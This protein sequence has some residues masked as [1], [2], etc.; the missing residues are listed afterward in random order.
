M[1]GE[2]LTG[3][4]S[5]ESAFYTCLQFLVSTFSCRSE[6]HTEMNVHFFSLLECNCF[7]HYLRSVLQRNECLI[8]SAVVICVGD[9][10][11]YSETPFL[12]VCQTTVFSF[13]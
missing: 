7:V 10:Q 5:L 8:H 3:K 2:K 9:K 11:G 13:L 4:I 6:C 1:K 12:F